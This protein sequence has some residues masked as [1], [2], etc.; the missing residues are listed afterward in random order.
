MSPL[1]IIAAHK[2]QG[3]AY[4]FLNALSIVKLSGQ[5]TGGAFALI[6]ETVPAGRSSPYHLHHKEDETFYVIEGELSFYSGTNKFK[7]TP[8]STVFLP[9]KIPHGFR[10][11]TPSRILILTTPA[12]FDQFVTEAGEPATELKIPAPREPDFAVLTQ[13]AAKYQIEILGPLPD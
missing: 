3:R 10:A 6:E 11:D 7:G 9:R 13:L 4:W 5:Q 12:G 2:D 8:G 1:E